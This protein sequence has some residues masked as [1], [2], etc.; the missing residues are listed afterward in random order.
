MTLTFGSLF[1]GVG[2]A[3]LGMEQAGFECVFQVEWDKHCQSILRRHWPDV[4]K[5]GDVCE[6][7]GHDLPE[8]DVIFFGSP[9]QDLSVAG[10]R[11]GLDGGRSSMFF[12]ATRIIKEMRDASAS[13]PTGP[14]PRA[15]IWENVPGAL[16][17]NNGEDFHAVLEALGDIG[18]VDIQ[19]SVLDAQ[20]F[21]V[22]QRRRRIFLVAIFDPATADRCDGPLLPVCEGRP[23][24]FAKG[25]AKGEGATGDAEAS[26]D[27]SGEGYRML[28]FGHYT[29]DDTA[30]ALK[31][32]DYKD[33]TDLAVIPFVKAKRAM[34]DTD[35][36]RWEATETA[37]TLNA[38]DNGGE[39]RATVLMPI[40]TH[41]VV[42][43]LQS[44]QHKGVNH[45]GARD[46]QLVVEAQ[47]IIFDGTRHDDF[48]M[49]TEIVPTLK[50]RMGTGGGQVPMVAEPVTVFQPG[51]MVRL[52][53]GVWQDQVPTL[54]AEAKRGDNEPHIAQP[55][56]FDTQF[57]SNANVF[58]DQSPT[59]K[60]SQ[61][62]PSIATTM[63][64]RRLTPL[65]CERLMGFPDDHTRW[66]DEGKEQ[67]D[68]H[69]YKQC[70]NAVASPVARWVGQHVRRV[71]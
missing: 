51:T 34:S 44:R 16:S 28:G 30:S 68:T 19:W 13:R 11:A 69:R 56:S 67:A 65:E 55:Y 71:L 70:G 14:V 62:S 21:G 17:S 58:V 32:R 59:L 41:D 9:C 25:R 57:G 33:A 43:T 48:R 12:E 42:G 18:A 20:H 60:A 54:R 49:D 10:K 27:G 4:P 37:P 53:G 15:V 31:Q 3:D 23:R 24:D 50:Q 64:V 6:V 39:S 2:G 52:G 45:E 63:A 29:A 46:G 5:W 35:D 61:Q 26:F 22:P 40:L 38:F 1:A 66:T 8:A 47:P 36:D 7:S